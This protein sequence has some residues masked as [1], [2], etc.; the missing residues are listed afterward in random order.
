MMYAKLWREVESLS[1]EEFMS[2][3]GIDEFEHLSGLILFKGQTDNL[4]Y[5]SATIRSMGVVKVVSESE[6]EVNEEIR[7]ECIDLD[8]DFIGG[9]WDKTALYSSVIRGVRIRRGCPKVDIIVTDNAIIL[10]K[11]TGERDRASI[12]LHTKKPYRQ[13]GTLNH[14]MARLLVNLSR[15]RR[16]FL[17]P[18]VGLGS[19][20]IEASWLGLQCIGVDPV[21]NNLRKARA[22][23]EFASQECDLVQ[24]LVQDF[25]VRGVDGIGTDPPYGRSTKVEGTIR[26]IYEALFD[27]ASN[28]GKSTRL[29][30]LSS[31]DYD[32]VDEIRTFGLRVKSMHFIYSH[33]S[34]TRT[35]YVVER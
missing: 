2:L 19:T 24:S 7:G 22:N 21:I 3:S 8:F 32:W 6:T 11:R 16:V 15:A 29:V 17:D 27:L 12:L 33:K 23:L 10:G 30:F 9:E 14:T 4:A 1:I 18:F 31:S 28:L 20:A 26:G 34:L 13:S 35:L 25:G 5:R